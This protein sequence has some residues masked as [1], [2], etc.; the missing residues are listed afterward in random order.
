MACS[1]RGEIAV[2][3]PAARVRGLCEYGSQVEV[4]EAIPIRRYFR[5]GMEI[6]RMGT[7]YHEEGSLESAFIL[8]SKFITLFVEKL[9]NHPEYKEASAGEKAKIKRKLLS[10]FPLAEQIKKQLSTRYEQEFKKY[11]EQKKAEEEA[12]AREFE[13]RAAEVALS[14]QLESDS[15]GGGGGGGSD[16]QDASFGED[17]ELY[18]QLQE[19]ERQK[20]ASG[21]VVAAGGLP[22]QLGDLSLHDSSVTDSSPESSSVSPTAHTPDGS[23]SSSQWIGSSDP[24]GKLY[25]HPSIESPNNFAVSRQA[26]REPPAGYIA[27]DLWSVGE[28]TQNR[29]PEIPSR[30]LKPPAPE[31]NR[32]NKPILG[33]H[34]E[35]NT[36]TKLKSI[37]MR[38]VVI[39]SM[40]MSRFLDLA[41][42]NTNRNVETCGILAGSLERNKFTITHLIIP[43]QSG[44]ADSCS[45]ENEEAIFDYQDNHDL[46]TLGWIHTHP[47]Q[48]AFMSSVDLHTHCSYQL[49]L[50]EAVAI[51]CSPKHKENGF[52]SLTPEYGLNAIASCRKSG[53]HPHPKEPPLYKDSSHVRLEG[54]RGVEIVDLRRR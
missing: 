32:A 25:P 41:Q 20:M 14:L 5:S 47:S 2:R 44:T 8:Y 36:N 52:F 23:Q 4:D 34:Q 9:P 37:G 15:Q 16:G 54:S 38:E 7:V 39:P 31:I 6:L 24:K 50:P 1:P 11:L 43:K 45:T 22:R 29:R 10:V 26:S 48:T 12:K 28:T 40:V 49:M 42:S 19:K 30:D 17:A 53:F 18:R 46:I 51:V 35:W 33:D 3:E 27:N 13:L 21:A